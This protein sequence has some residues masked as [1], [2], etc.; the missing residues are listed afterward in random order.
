MIEE[1]KPF[2]GRAIPGYPPKIA[3]AIMHAQNE[4]AYRKWHIEE[5]GGEIE[6][7]EL[8]QAWRARVSQLRA[9]SQN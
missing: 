3:H 1:D 4:L 6:T 9:T 7:D 8:V 2:K 5:E